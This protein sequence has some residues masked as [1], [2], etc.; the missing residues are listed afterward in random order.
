VVVND[1]SRLVGGPE[2]LLQIT[3]VVPTSAGRL[4]FARPE[5]D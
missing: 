1:G 3:S 2:V 5:E 4:L